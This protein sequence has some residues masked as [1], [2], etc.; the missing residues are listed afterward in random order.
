MF[1]P[2]TRRQKCRWEPMRRLAALVLLVV[3]VIPILGVAALAQPP[4]PP[5]PADRP[6][7]AEALERYRANVEASAWE[8]P[9]AVRDRAIVALAQEIA[10]LEALG[11][12]RTAGSPIERVA[13]AF[14]P[15]DALDRATMA[16][17]LAAADQS[18]ADSKAEISAHVDLSTH[19]AVSVFDELPVGWF[20]GLVAG[21]APILA[22][23]PYVAALST[24]LS[25]GTTRLIPPHELGVEFVDLPTELD[26]L[27]DGWGTMFDTNGPTITTRPSLGPTLT[28]IS[29]TTAVGL[30]L[31]MALRRRKSVAQGPDLSDVV[32]K[33]ISAGSESE[34]EAV[35]MAGL[36]P[37]VDA[38]S[39]LLLINDAGDLRRAGSQLPLSGSKLTRVV[40]TGAPL[41]ELVE[42]DPALG[43][44]RATVMAVPIISGGAVLAVLSVHRGPDHP[45]GPTERHVLQHLA[46]PIA[47]ALANVDRLGSMT[48][49]AMVDGLTS[50]GNRRRM[51]RDLQVAADDSKNTQVGFAMIDVDH[52]KHFNDTNGHSA[53]DDALKTVAAT[54]AAS[55]REGDVV[56]RYGGEEFS[57]L[58]PDTSAHT[59]TLVAERI[60]LAVE[61]AVITGEDTQPGG[62]LTVSV[63][64]STAPAEGV[65]ALADRADRAL[66]EAKQG[67]RNR[68]VAG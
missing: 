31:I 65:D 41:S 47:A 68:I 24:L 46:P 6:F 59:A 49:L 37:M 60:R 15:I 44:V 32:R 50:L 7:S 45:F 56:Y 48:E 30:L 55:V 39:G 29:T 2:F 11:A 16:D 40:E 17:A 28:V 66:Y 67:G 53:G 57:V 54:I 21:T 35:V 22:S 51:D 12:L 4:G 58:L 14:P 8:V 13:Q 64:V 42:S 10:L 1:W 36:L 43:R 18:L 20:D 25:R 26:R 33:L 9:D 62:C 3:L 63:G 61:A 5:R 27:I 52:F 38:G 19:T 34:V 23:Q